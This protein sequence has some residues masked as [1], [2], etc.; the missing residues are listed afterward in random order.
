MDYEIEPVA[1]WRGYNIGL[2][3]R[4]EPQAVKD[5]GNQASA[6]WLG[7]LSSMW[8]AIG[9]PLDEKRLAQY[10]RM[11]KSVPLGLLDEAVNLAVRNNGQYQ[12]VPTI[13]AIWDAIRKILGNP[14]D[15]DIALER[16]IDRNLT[17]VRFE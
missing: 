12:S 16:W 11:L 13:G 15:V 4:A 1:N 17:M 10:A 14:L 7:V 5:F 8:D 9:K 3:Q 2:T 6:E